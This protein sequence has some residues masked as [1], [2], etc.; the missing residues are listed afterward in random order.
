MIMKTL[1][2]TFAFLFIAGALIAQQVDR[3][4]VII[5]SATQTQ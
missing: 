3:D 5:E 4:K 1:K 2:L